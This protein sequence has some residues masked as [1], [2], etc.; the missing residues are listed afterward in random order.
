MDNVNTHHKHRRRNNILAKAGFHGL[1]IIGAVFC[2]TMATL[3]LLQMNIQYHIRPDRLSMMSK[4][5]LSQIKTE[6]KATGVVKATGDGR[7]LLVLE[8]G[9]AQSE[10][11]K[12]MWIPILDQMKIPYETCDVSS[13]KSNLLKLYD[14]LIIAITNLAK[15]VKV[16]IQTK[17][18]EDFQGENLNLRIDQNSSSFISKIY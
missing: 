18:Y 12:E 14:K 11:A 3:V 7:V 15:H 1:Y 5:E 10:I 9:D 8:E 4:E 6:E 17:G 16:I 2:L 13:F